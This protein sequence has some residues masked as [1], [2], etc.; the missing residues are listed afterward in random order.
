[1]NRS[2]MTN[3]RIK[4]FNKRLRLKTLQKRLDNIIIIMNIVGYV[5]FNKKFIAYDPNKI[6]IQ[7]KGFSKD[8]DLNIST[9]WFKDK[10]KK[11]LLTSSD[12]CYMYM[13]VFNGPVYDSKKIIKWQNDFLKGV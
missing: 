7:T 10:R 8:L 2:P 3:K 6:F 5:V 1:M 12:N 9:I 11:K 13:S 4:K